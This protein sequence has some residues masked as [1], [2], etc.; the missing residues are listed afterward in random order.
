[1][2]GICLSKENA[3]FF[4]IAL[5]H[6][7]S[8]YNKPAQ[9]VAPT[10]PSGKYRDS[11]DCVLS[12]LPGLFWGGPCRVQAG[13]QSPAG[14]KDVVRMYFGNIFCAVWMGFL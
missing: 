7:N 14:C 3:L 13:S 5:R 9:E 11:R 4:G 6:M 8:V 1:M 12:S 2:R 10:G